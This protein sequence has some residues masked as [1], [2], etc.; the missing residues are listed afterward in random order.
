MECV[1]LTTFGQTFVIWIQLE[2]KQQGI[3][4]TIAVLISNDNEHVQL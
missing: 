4:Y 1:T 3:S 2:I